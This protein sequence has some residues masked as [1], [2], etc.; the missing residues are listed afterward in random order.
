MT[1]KWTSKAMLEQFSKVEFPNE[2]THA[3][4]MYKRESHHY[5]GVAHVLRSQ[6][7]AFRSMEGV[8]PGAYA[9][10]SAVKTA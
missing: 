8:D 10:G 3:A 9:H 4:L 6:E 7:E 2:I 5:S 1:N